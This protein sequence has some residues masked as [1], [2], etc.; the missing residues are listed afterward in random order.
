VDIIHDLDA[1]A[2]EQQIRRRTR[3]H[4]KLLLLPSQL[5]NKAPKWRQVVEQLQ[6]HEA[7]RQG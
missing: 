4:C 5:F 7:R 1:E 2:E 3:G 6:A